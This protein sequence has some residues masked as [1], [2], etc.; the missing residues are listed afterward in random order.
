MKT[1][2]SCFRTPDPHSCPDPTAQ[3][4]SR[5]ANRLRGPRA[6]Q[7]INVTE[8][9][10]HTLWPG[11]ASKHSLLGFFVAVVRRGGEMTL[12]TGSDLAD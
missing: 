12:L 11:L 10:Q 8:V 2:R 3:K 1:S 9:V 4:S 6:P 7:P 5:A